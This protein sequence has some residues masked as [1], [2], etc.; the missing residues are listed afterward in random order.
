MRNQ[1]KEIKKNGE[2]SENL[3]FFIVNSQTFIENAKKMKDYLLE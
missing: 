1:I 3:V 2:N